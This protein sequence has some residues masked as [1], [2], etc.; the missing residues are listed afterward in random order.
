[1]RRII[2][3]AGSAAVVIVVVIVLVVA[4]SPT[5]R[6][7]AKLLPANVMPVGWLPEDFAGALKGT[8]CL[9]AVL[10]PKG[11][12]HQSL[13]DTIYINNGSTPP[14]I[15]EALATYR[16]PA[17][18]Y[19]RVVAALDRCRH[20]DVG[21]TGPAGFTGTVRPMLAV[22]YGQSSAMYQGVLSNYAIPVT[23]TMDLVVVRQGN[24]VMELFESDL[25]DGQVNVTQFSHYISLALRR[26]LLTAK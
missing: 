17:Q 9:A 20:L 2:V 25:G 12:A 6:L 7:A 4:S 11:L 8:G 1:V 3:L 18:A 21:G 24:V 15:G 13:V 19:E 10:S 5:P 26:I 16:H 14:E 23:V 22:S